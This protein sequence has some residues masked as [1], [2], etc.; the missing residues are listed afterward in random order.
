MHGNS[1]SR[2]AAGIMMFDYLKKFVVASPPKVERYNFFI[3]IPASEIEVAE[4]A[5]GVM[6][7]QPLRAFYIQV[8]YGNYVGELAKA[9]YGPLVANEVLRPR[10]VVEV[11]A[12]QGRFPYPFKSRRGELPFFRMWEDSYLQVNA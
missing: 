3:P 12:G 2:T 5:L 7:P 4:A 8:G 11:L 10:E 1:S 6:F 9:K